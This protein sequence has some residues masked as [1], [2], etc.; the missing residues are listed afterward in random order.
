LKQTSAMVAGQRLDERVLV[1]GGGAAG[2]ATSLAL[3]RLGIPTVIVERS[4]SPGAGSAWKIGEGLPPAANP[5]LHRLGVWDQTR[6]DGHLLSFGNAAAWGSPG[7][8]DQSFLFDPNGAGWHLDRPRFDAMLLRSARALGAQLLV[9]TASVY[10]HSTASSNVSLRIVTER[11][12]EILARPRFVVDASG[13]TA[14]IARQQNP[15]RQHPDRLVGIVGVL[16]TR[17]PAGDPDSRTIVEAVEDGW[18]YSAAV[19]GGRL[20]VAFMTDGDIASHR[21]T[22]RLDGWSALLGETT[23][24]R[25]RVVRQA[26]RLVVQPRVVLA[27]SSR[28]SC[29]A[30]SSWLAVGDAA[31]AHD[32]L[33]SQGLA[34]ALLLGLSAAEVIADR[35]SGQPD[36]PHRYRAL[37]ERLHAEYLAGL[38]YHYQQERRWPDAPFWARR[39]RTR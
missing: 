29:V 5:F 7:L 31:I 17:D 19:P 8:V 13:R 36:A 24:T 14:T 1:V 38:A 18:W 27:N 12:D 25:A 11:G 4:A 28:H 2:A 3:Q 23:H 34:S 32:P 10:D 21:A 30:G 33:S 22:H 37:V 26:C 6:V 35:L 15:R 16:A 20:V 39:H 9:G